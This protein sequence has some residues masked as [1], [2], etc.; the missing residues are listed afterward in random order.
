M[1]EFPLSLAARSFRVLVTGT[2]SV[3]SLITLFCLPLFVSGCG[4]GADN[5]V[6]A[7]VG[8]RKITVAYY[9]ERLGKLTQADLPRDESNLPL[10]TATL[11][12]KKAFLDVI[13][14]KELMVLKAK[15]L[16]LDKDQGVTGAQKAMMDY[17]AG[18]ILHEDIIDKPT[19]VISDEQLADYYEKLKEVR[20]CSFIICNFREDAVKARQAII[21][22]GLWEDVAE[23][24]HDG[25]RSPKG[26]YRV[27]ITW[28][29]WDDSFEQA[30]FS[31]QEG[32]ISQ[33][34]ETVYGYWI[35]RLEGI[36]EERV[37]PLDTMQDRVLASIKMRSI[38][39]ARKKFMVESRARHDFEMNEDA[40]WTVYQGLPEGEVILDPETKKP[41]PREQLK[42]LDIPLED[43]DMFFYQV[44]LE[45]ELQTMTVGSYK[46]IFDKMSTFQRPKKSELLGGLRQKMLTEIDK[47]LI[48]QEAR[49]RGYYK[50]TRVLESVGIR[51]EEMMVSKLHS[52][53]VDYEEYIAPQDLEEFWVAVKE[54]YVVPE[55]RGGLVVYCENQEQAVR[56]RE[57]AVAGTGWSVILEEYGSVEENKQRDGQLDIVR[58]NVSH[59]V[60]DQLFTLAEK[61]DVSQPFGVGG[62]WAV[63][64]LTIIEE[65]YQQELAEV[66]NELGQRIK[67]RR[68]D[69]ALRELLL[70]WRDHFGVVIYEDKLDRLDSWEELSEEAAVPPPAT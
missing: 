14:N 23:E 41:V 18:L 61:G 67:M 28:G 55:G 25:D 13:I 3:A 64:R 19:N 17:N 68:Q 20:Q 1:S 10:D 53:V 31:L 70:E 26:D 37:P 60:S 69:E 36:S 16:G 47:Q 39:L 4:G 62:K 63:V 24:Y 58:A 45:G 65:S 40:L 12:G 9:E 59:P 21:D 30:I 57:A 46:L 52:E 15:E 33:P 48:T 29:R 54:Q 66:R 6:L 44:R 11:E 43:M 22:G 42:P 8:D 5:T 49:E 27:K 35:L 50:D 51:V 38:N 2:L 32:D 56:A 7:E 34:V